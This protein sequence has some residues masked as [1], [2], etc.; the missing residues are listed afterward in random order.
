VEVQDAQNVLREEEIV[1]CLISEGNSSEEGD[2]KSS[3]RIKLFQ[4]KEHNW[5]EIV[6]KEIS[7]KMYGT[8]CVS[9]AEWSAS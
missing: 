6:V 9:C 1:G 7:S 3:W 8:R 5:E 4:G 2:E